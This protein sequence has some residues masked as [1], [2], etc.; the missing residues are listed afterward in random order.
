[1]KNFILK[2]NPISFFIEMGFGIYYTIAAS[3]GNGI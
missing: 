1:M 3:T 2:K